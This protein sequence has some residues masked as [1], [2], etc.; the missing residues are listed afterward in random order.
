MF[1]LFKIKEA[2]RAVPES[3]YVHRAIPDDSMLEELD[4]L[5]VE[6]LGLSAKE[7]SNHHR[8]GQLYNLIVDKKLPEKAGY[9]DARDYFTKNLANLSQASLTL[10]GTVARNFSE[11]V[12]RLFGVTCLS[13]LL[14]YKDA[15]G[16]E[17]NPEEP[18]PMPIEVPDEKGIVSIQPFSACTVEQLRRA[19][20]RKRKPAS[21]KPLPPEKVVLA[22]QYSESVARRFPQGKGTLVKVALRNQKGKAVL[23]FKGIPVEQVLQ[24]AE[25][26]T[27]QLPPVHELPKPPLPLLPS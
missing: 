8:M 24:L 18:G 9:K 27:A 7:S 2:A 14:T 11:P 23:D 15:A 10:Y 13:L 16:L 22:E 12:T 6:L 19:I 25:A 4:Q 5:R 17:L 3:T 20:Q 21:T 26:L 1:R